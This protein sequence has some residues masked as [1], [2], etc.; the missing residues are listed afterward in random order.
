[1]KIAVDA[2][3]GDKAPQEIVRGAMRAAR[4]DDMRIILV[5]DEP[6]LKPLVAEFP[7]T[8]NV[9]ICHTPEWVRMDEAPATALKKK[10]NASV[11]VCAEL[12]KKGEVDA[13]V[14]AGNTGALIATALFTLGRIPGI[15][16]PALATM[17]PTLT[18]PAL[19]MDLGATVDCKPE[20]LVQFAQMGC[21]YVEK[22]LGRENP[23]VGLVNIGEEP[24]KGN[25]LV[26]ETWEMLHAEKSLN[27]VG[28]VEP[29]QLINGYVDVAVADG[30]V[31]NLMLKMG[32]A[33]GE[34]ILKSVKS[35]IGWNPLYLGAAAALTPVLKEM[36][37]SLDHSEYGGAPLLGVSGVV[38]KSHGR[39]KALTIRNAIRVANRMAESRTVELIAST[40]GDSKKPTPV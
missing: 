26:K 23:R 32:E 30:F 4:R 19:L 8:N 1:M 34:L 29:K 38:I 13:M 28:S 20:Y 18:V 16:R 24:T 11:V 10:K 22:V 37:K 17:W 5:G 21:V 27:F 7:R 3:G 31:G 12:L 33:V 15:R 14:S 6:A 25:A 36:K 2:M 39:A 35:R 40:M 9:T